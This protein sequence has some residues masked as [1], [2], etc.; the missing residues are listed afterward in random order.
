[1]F[2]YYG[3]MKKFMFNFSPE[4]AHHFAEFFFKNGANYAPFILSPLAEH[5]FIHDKR[6]EQ[7]IFGKTF[8]N[9]LGL[10]AGFDKNATMIKMLTA[11]GF[12]HIEYGTITPEPQSGN[13]KPRCFRFPEQESIQ[14]AMGFNN[15]GMYKVGKRLESLYPFA[16]PLGANIGK[17]KVTSAE[18]ALKD[19]EKLIKRFKD[20]SDYLVI[21]ISSPNTPGLRDLQNEQFIKDLF[22]MAKEL[23]LKPVLLKIAP[24]LEINDALHVSATALENGAAG[25]VATNTTIDYSLLPN[26]KDFGGLSGKVLTEKSFVMFEALAK[27]F[28]GKTTLISVGGIDSA[29]EAYRR[30]KAGASLIQIYTAFIFKG[31]SLNRAINLGILERMEKDGFS[32]ISEVIGS[33]RR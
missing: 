7:T 5:F 26:A 24:D 18:N 31:P 13:P 4:N 2:N 15:E 8:L 29:D 17:N 1:M 19:Y 11:L 14:N 20:L 33:D 10:G 16:T 23:T 27:E 28:F 3:L 6:L 25:I 12:G 22:V 30:L 9:P 32:H 21:N